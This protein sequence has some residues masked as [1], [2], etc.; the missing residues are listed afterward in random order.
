MTKKYTNVNLPEGIIET[1][2][3]IVQI[4]ELGYTSRAE[5]VKDAIRKS[6][7]ELM[8][9]GMIKKKSTLISVD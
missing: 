3:E 1:I 2:D 8:K 5:F 7:Q 9:S 6:I 4:K